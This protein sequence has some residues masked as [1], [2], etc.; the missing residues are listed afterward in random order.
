MLSFLLDEQISHVVAE[1]VRLKRPDIR[2]ESVL[3]WQ[4]GDL[5]G[6][7]DVIV[8]SVAHRERLSL[9][10]YDQKSIPPLLMELAM[11]DGHHSGVIFVDK[12]T[13][14]SDS[15]GVLVQ[16]LIAFYDHYNA[17]I[18]TDIVMF[19]SPSNV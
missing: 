17:L 14:P 15:I 2:I 8:L 6:A 12:N 11:S 4:E 10:T 9:V 19:R 7:A 3:H 5:S 18:W 13:I 16:A 1:Q